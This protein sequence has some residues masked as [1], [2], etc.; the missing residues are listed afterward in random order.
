LKITRIFTRF[1]SVSLLALAPLASAQDQS[2]PADAPA[3]VWSV[4]PIDFSGL[5]DGY[6]TFNGNH[7]RN[8]DGTPGENTL[9]NFNYN[10]NQFSLGMAKLTMQHD[11]D[12]VGFRVDLGFGKAFDNI[13]G[14]EPSGSSGFMRNVEQAYVSVKSKAGYEADFGEFV[15]S[16]GAEVIEAKDNWN[17]SRGILFAWAIPYYHFGLRTVL[18]V[19]SHFTGGVQVVNG[20][21]NVEDNNSGK[22]L[23]LTGSFTA[24]KVTWGNNYYTGPE[25]AGTNT[26]WRNLYDSVLLLTPSDKFSAYLNFDYAKQNNADGTSAIWTGIAG[27]A[28]FQ[29]NDKFAITPRLE[30]FNDHNGGSTG[31]SQ[32]LKEF[33]IT[34]EM[35]AAQGVL[36]RLE[37]RHDWSDQAFFQSGVDGLRDHQDTVTLGVLAFFGPKH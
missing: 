36:A 9:Y 24:G 26:G 34:A 31:T 27:A 4:G 35:K 8:E 12:P 21:N 6:Y 15:T 10:A 3:S 5:I 37:Y 23:G 32:A 1:A 14:S 7:P 18:P 30:W 11:A 16:A 13:H 22:T 29:L 17:Y 28:K 19:G 25:N 20:W 2:A 33:T